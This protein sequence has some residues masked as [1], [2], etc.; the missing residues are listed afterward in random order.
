MIRAVVDPSVLVSAFIGDPEAG[1][2][3]LVTAWRDRRFVLVVSP[4]LLDELTDVLGR[5]K[6]D[7]WASQGRAPAY[8]AALR[9]RSEHRSDVPSAQPVEVRD[10]DDHYLVAL[11]RE[12]QTDHLVSVDGDLLDAE[13]D[14]SVVDPAVF[15]A[16]LHDPVDGEHFFTGRTQAGREL[17][18][19]PQGSA[20]HP[21]G[22]KIAGTLDGV[23][24]EI[25][26]ITQRM[27]KGTGSPVIVRSDQ[28]TFTA[29]ADPNAPAEAH[30]A[31]LRLYMERRPPGGWR[32]E[33]ERSRFEDGG[34]RFDVLVTNDRVSTIIELRMSEAKTWTRGAPTPPSDQMVAAHV[35]AILR[36]A[37]WSAIQQ[38]A[39]HPTTVLAGRPLR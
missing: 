27:G 30:S 33:V 12:A 11:A 7:R 32:T 21:A 5:P 29:V 9:A 17:R 13:L 37:D 15:V 25:S 16:G 8:I 24:I 23:A 14:V 1:P 39:L 31:A 22:V 26:G 18:L 19:Y 34:W 2:G 20:N 36:H 38:R 28:G 3:R 10:P 35:A 6:F 4:L